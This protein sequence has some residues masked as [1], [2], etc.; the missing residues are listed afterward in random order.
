MCGLVNEGRAQVWGAY[1]LRGELRAERA[2]GAERR[3]RGDEARAGHVPECRGAA[4]AQDDLVVLGD[5]QEGAQSFLQ[6]GDHA[7]NGGSA[8]GGSHEER[9]GKCLDLRGAHLGGAA[10]E[11]SVSGKDVLGDVGESHHGNSLVS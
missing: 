7:S 9:R 8:V 1:R 4:V 5:R 10:A 11:T 3:A 6:R 2:P